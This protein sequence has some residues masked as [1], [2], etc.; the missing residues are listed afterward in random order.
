MSKR[1]SLYEVAELIRSKAKPDWELD[2]IFWACERR[3]DYPLTHY[4][5]ETY[6]G[7]RREGA[8]EARLVSDAGAL[9]RYIEETWP[10][11]RIN[12]RLEKGLAKIEV[13]ISDLAIG[14]SST[15]T[16]KLALSELNRGL[17]IAF[18]GAHEAALSLQ[19]R[20]YAMDGV[21]EKV[22]PYKDWPIEE[23][24]PGR[25]HSVL[26]DQQL[27][28]TSWRDRETAERNAGSNHKG[29]YG[30]LVCR[31]RYLKLF[32]AR[33]IEDDAPSP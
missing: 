2:E 20:L 6:E 30:M 10:K 21:A 33:E 32:P 16:G 18:A 12:M 5:H 8:P 19:Q 24:A 17:A 4:D 13:V 29:D 26:H 31:E 23:F 3:V 14:A 7:A 1:P 15:F 28:L 25:F 27:A 11:T 22:P 9:T